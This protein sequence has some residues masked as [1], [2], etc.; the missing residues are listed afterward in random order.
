MEGK[1]K[2]E[3]ALFRQGQ[4]VTTVTQRRCTV[5][6]SV[7]WGKLT[8]KMRLEKKFFNKKIHLLLKGFL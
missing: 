2:P 7:S 8:T 5:E 1:L 3:E 6:M 4:E